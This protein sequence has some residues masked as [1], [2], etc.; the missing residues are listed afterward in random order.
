MRWKK[1]SEVVADLIDG[2]FESNTAPRH[3]I[4]RITFSLIINEVG[5]GD[6]S[7]RYKCIVVV[8]DPLSYNLETRI[9]LETKQDVLITLKV[10]GMHALV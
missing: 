8:K 7:A 6:A 4:D 9:R 10:I 1:G 3:S 2:T 5:L